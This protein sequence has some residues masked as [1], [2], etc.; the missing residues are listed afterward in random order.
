VDNSEV[1][2]LTPTLSINP[3]TDV[4]L[5]QIS[6]EFEVYLDSNLNDLVTS[7]SGMG[8]SWQ[9][10][11]I[12]VDN[13]RYYWRARAVD[14]YGTPSDWSAI[15]S[16]FVNIN[17]QPTAPTLNNPVSGGTVTSLT[18]A[19]SVNNSTDTDNDTLDY[20]FELYSD[21][22]LTNKVASS[23][24]SQSNLIT[25]WTVFP[26]LTDNTTY[27]WRVRAKDGGLASS[28]MPTAVF[29]VNTSG[30]DT[31]VEIA[32]SQYVSASAQITQTVEVTDIGSPI[33]GVVVEIPP[34]AL[35]TDATITIGVV[36]NPPALPVNTKA[37]GRVI[38][39]GPS[40]TTFSIPVTIK[41][42]YTQ[43]DLDNAGVSD[44]AELEVF[45]YNTMT[46]SW[47]EN[48]IDSIDNVNSLLIY[49][50]SHFSMYT[51][52]K[53]VTSQSSLSGRGGGSSSGVCFIATAAYGSQM[54]LHEGS[55]G[56]HPPENR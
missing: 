34:G 30:A 49:K 45:T 40:D 39:F 18:P 6:Y 2:I 33:K 48:A 54:Q 43:D 3:S 8:E 55:L 13:V 20:E 31:I 1:A 17:Y 27:Y 21:Q 47:E 42:P 32:A 15:G 26:L 23:T 35:F 5:D 12:L 14:E 53:A 22:N 11:V 56:R 37:I 16:F 51:T 50:V 10:D 4:D 41:I 24:V 19:L 9:V 46:L 36:I 44:P 38:E 52:G 25:S 28:W 29:V 7:V